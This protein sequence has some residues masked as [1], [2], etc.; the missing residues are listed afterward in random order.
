MQ[1]EFLSGIYIA[2]RALLMQPKTRA[3]ASSLHTP[4]SHA[5]GLLC[6]DTGCG[7][8]RKGV[9][10]PQEL[11]CNSSCFS[12]PT[13]QST[14]DRGWVVTDCMFSSKEESW[15]RL[16]QEKKLEKISRLQVCLIIV[17]ELP[18]SCWPLKAHYLRSITGQSSH[19]KW[20]LPS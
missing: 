20:S 3:P 1:G 5:R 17:F 12:Q 19:Q 18:N 9:H 6:R 14:V 10:G 8:A 2:R 13:Q 7:L 4:V 11:V 15:N 16:F